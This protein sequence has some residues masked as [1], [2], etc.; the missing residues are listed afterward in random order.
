MQAQFA[1]S[2]YTASVLTDNART[3]TI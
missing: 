1:S 3:L 2:M